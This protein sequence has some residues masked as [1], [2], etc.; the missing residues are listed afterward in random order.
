MT[1]AVAA[2]AE[3]LKHLSRTNPDGPALSVLSQDEIDAAILL[4]RTTK[5]KRGD[6]LTIGAAVALIAQLG[7]YTG[8]SSGGPPGTTVLTRGLH[9]VVVAWR[10]LAATRCD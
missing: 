3:S 6:V 5:H 8:K 1:A 9:D 7:G 4:S 2:R 10:A